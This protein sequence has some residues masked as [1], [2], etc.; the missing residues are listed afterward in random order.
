MFLYLNQI[1]KKFKSIKDLPA[2]LKQSISIQDQIKVIRQALGMTQSQLAKRLGYSSNNP[3]A[4]LENKEIKNP[5]LETLV[6]YAETLECHLLLRL[7][8]KKEIKN[9][10]TDAADKKAKE[11]V[12]LSVGSSALEMQKPNKETIQEE[13]ERVKKDLLEKKRK[14]IWEK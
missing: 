9:I 1:S 6:K 5:T 13:I 12:N 11:I 2:W 4:E 14:M 3:V 7:V 8:P 10:L